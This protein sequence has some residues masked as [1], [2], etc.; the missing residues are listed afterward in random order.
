MKQI[1]MAAA[2]LALTS[3]ALKTQMVALNALPR[4]RVT[5]NL[6]PVVIESVVDAREFHTLPDNEGPRLD[7]KI[8]GQLGA[9]GRAR[10]IAGMPRG[11]LVTLLEKG[12][13]ADAVRET[14]TGALESRGY[15]VVASEQAPTDAPRISVTIREF[16]SYMPFSFG[17]TLTWTQQM[18]AWVATDITVKSPSLQRE[19]SVNGYGAHTIQVYSKENILQAY[20]L[21]MADYTEKLDAKLGAL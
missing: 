18:K 13:V 5:G 12:N 9:E 14:I 2:L 1:I 15:R 7:A 3:C 16:W 21:A 17:R 10:A 19:F 11:A 8:A 6:E 20:D 4:D